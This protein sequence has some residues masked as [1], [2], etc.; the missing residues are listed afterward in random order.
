[1]KRETL[2]LILLI[3]T[4]VL[5]AATLTFV[6]HG[7]SWVALSGSSEDCN[8]LGV[9]LHG[10]LYTYGVPTDPL[11]T[12]TASQDATASDDLTSSITDGSTD[13][14]IKAIIMEVDSGGGQPV[15]GEEIA[16]ALKNVSKPTVAFIRSAGDSAAYMAATGAKTIFAS[17]FSDVGSIGVTQSYSDTHIQDQQNGITWNQLSSGPFKDTGD[18]EK[19]LT[20]AERTL[21]MRDV[22]IAYQDFVALVAENRHLDV[23]KVTSLADGSSMLGEAALQNGLIDRIGGLP[24]VESYLKDQIGTDPI[25]CWR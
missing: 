20:P 12:S 10:S 17:K 6:L 7:A 11:S 2:T 15:A 5:S 4:V 18:T 9:K 22:N 16:N 24:E 25:V 13:S 19:A 8:V 23:Q 21:L 3:A 1:M 14:S